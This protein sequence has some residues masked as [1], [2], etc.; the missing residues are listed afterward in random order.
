MRVR[1]MLIIALV[2]LIMVFAIS[3]DDST[4]NPIDAAKILAVLSG[5]GDLK[6]T[7]DITIGSADSRVEK[8]IVTKDVKLD[9]GG[10]TLTYYTS[11]G[12]FN[13]EDCSIEITNGT[14]VVDSSGSAIAAVIRVGSY[15]K[16]SALVEHEGKLI[17][18][19]VKFTSNTS[20]I[21]PGG[22]AKATITNSTI[23]ASIW[24]LATNNTYGTDFDISVK[25]SRIIANASDNDN[26][27]LL[28]NNKGNLYVEDSTIQAA[29]QVVI[30]RGGTAEFKNVNLIKTAAGT[31]GAWGGGNEVPAGVVVIGEKSQG[32]KADS[33]V[34]FSGTN[35]I[36]LPDGYSGNEIYIMGRDTYKATL[37]TNG[38]LAGTKIT[39]GNNTNVT[40]DGNALTSTDTITLE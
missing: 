16:D 3:C 19:G 13:V 1:N 26:T 22:K 15:Y 35:T 32:Y 24:P 21:L 30:V 6:L 11:D 14:L 2:M 34:T 28:I 27:G 4:K 25:N 20:G 23:T 37:T 17:L 8:V 12:F 39:I 36:K 18:D 40:V 5:G 29:R 31:D 10:K 7:S 33:T 38:S 9:L